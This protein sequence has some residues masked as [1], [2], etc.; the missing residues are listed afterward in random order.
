MLRK[1]LDAKV[2]IFDFTRTLPQGASDDDIYAFIEN[3]KNKKLRA[4]KYRSE[5]LSLAVDHIVVLS[6]TMPE[7]KA[8]SLDRWR[9]FLIDESK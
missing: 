7:I 9:I 8:L 4:D 3:C 5:V 2:L 1:H 6:N